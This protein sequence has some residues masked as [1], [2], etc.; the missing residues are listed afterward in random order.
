MSK[1]SW[2]NNEIKEASHVQ[3]IRATEHINRDK[4]KKKMLCYHWCG[5]TNMFNKSKWIC[6]L[7]KCKRYGKFKPINLF[8]SIIL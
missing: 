3:K 8:T 2:K 4:K 6:S 7:G 5:Q 1:G